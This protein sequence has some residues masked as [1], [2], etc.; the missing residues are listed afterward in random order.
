MIHGVI[1]IVWMLSI[2]LLLMWKQSRALVL[3]LDQSS[4]LSA[5]LVGLCADKAFA[6]LFQGFVTDSLE[7]RSG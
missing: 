1:H 4:T 3:R 7:R 6:E 5:H 2:W